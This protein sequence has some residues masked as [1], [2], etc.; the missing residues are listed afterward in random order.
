M[1]SPDDRAS[2]MKSK[3]LALCV[4]ALALGTQSARAGEVLIKPDEAA[5]PPAPAAARLSLVTRGITRRPN[6][7]LKSPAASVTSP[8]TFKLAFKAHG[9]STIKPGSFEAIYLKKPNVDLTA[10]ITPFLT[11][12]GVDMVGAEAPPGRHVIKLKITDSD[13]REGS[14]VIVLNVLK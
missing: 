5:L 2:A 8:F 1:W 6:V 9:G 11:A 4:L 14:A 7:L 3:L 12:K 13:G 10:R